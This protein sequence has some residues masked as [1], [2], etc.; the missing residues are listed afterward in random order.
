[1]LMLVLASGCATNY[2]RPMSGCE[3]LAVRHQAELRK[4]GKES[5]IAFIQYRLKFGGHAV[6][7]E[8]Q[9]NGKFKF[10]DP[11]LGR[12]LDRDEFRLKMIE[13][14]QFR[15]YDGVVSNIK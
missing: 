11:A 15:F 10:Y 1:M 4:Q 2:A 8:V 7:A 3:R 12:Y 5:Y 14:K 9:D 6:V 13:T